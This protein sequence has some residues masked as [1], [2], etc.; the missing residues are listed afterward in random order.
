MLSKMAKVPGGPPGLRAQRRTPYGPL[1][2]AVP[3]GA[4][5]GAE[6]GRVLHGLEGVT[7]VPFVEGVDVDEEEP[8]PA[9]V[10]SRVQLHL[11]GRPPGPP[12]PLLRG[13][14]RALAALGGREVQ[15]RRRRGELTRQV[16]GIVGLS[17][18]ALGGSAHH[19]PN[20]E[21]TGCCGPIQVRFRF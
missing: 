17:L 8:P 11:E 14:R 5:P 15:A 6:G 1:G 2:V 16:A 9:I 20:L 21:D 18:K 4:L 10:E 7:L 12:D 3:G 13:P 19:L